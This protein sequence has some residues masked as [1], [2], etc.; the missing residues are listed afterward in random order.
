MSQSLSQQDPGLTHTS[1]PA[2]CVCPALCLSVPWLQQSLSAS[3]T[4][5]M[6]GCFERCHGEELDEQ[7]LPSATFALNT[8]TWQSQMFHIRLQIKSVLFLLVSEQQFLEFSGTN[9]TVSC[10]SEVQYKIVR[11]WVCA[12]SPCR[13]VRVTGLAGHLSLSNIAIWHEKEKTG[14]YSGICFNPSL[15]YRDLWYRNISGQTCCLCS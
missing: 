6:R 1:K 15:A 4:A 14:N 5:W 13:S 2:C 7:C 12:H 10:H 8:C 9:K 11:R 3:L